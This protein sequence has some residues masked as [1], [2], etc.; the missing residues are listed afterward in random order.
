MVRRNFLKT[1]AVGASASVLPM[2]AMSQNSSAGRF[3]TMGKMKLTYRPYDLQM[4][5]VFTV[6]GSSRI[7]TQAVL[8]E[9]EY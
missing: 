9:I 7:T 6:A 8:T 1:M 4:R 5:H 2:V 3:P